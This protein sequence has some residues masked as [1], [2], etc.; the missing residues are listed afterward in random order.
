M[1][2]S[3]I[4]TTA[5]KRVERNLRHASDAVTTEHMLIDPLQIQFPVVHIGFALCKSVIVIV[6]IV[7]IYI[8]VVVVVSD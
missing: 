5:V 8:I 2:G 1:W 4:K 6:V 7:R 3:L